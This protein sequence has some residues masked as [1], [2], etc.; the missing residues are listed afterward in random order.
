MDLRQLETLVA[1]AEHGSF[2]AAAR[3]MYTVQSNVSAHISRLERELGVT[4]VDRQRG[5]LTDEGVTLVERARRILH[6]IQ[7][8][9]TELAARGEVRGDVRLGMIGTTARWA[10][11]LLLPALR[12]AYPGIHPLIHEGNTTNLVPRL[13]SGHLDGITVHLPLDEPDL[14]VEP[15]FA[16][17]LLLLAP[18][19]HRLAGRA[20]VGLE[21]LAVEP[22]ILPP[23][24]TAYRRV[25]DRAA[26]AVGISLRPIAEVDGVRLMASLAYEGFGATIVPATAIPRWLTGEFV[27]IPV[28][29]LPRRVVA[30]AQRKRPA[31]SSATRAA[32]AV[33]REVIATAGSDQTGVHVGQGAFPLS[34]AAG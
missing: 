1:V 32:A 6:D 33:L 16:E 3:A 2:S 25:L 34:R 24:H 11:P 8:V 4:L 12:H 15:L 13:L 14:A 22:L 9:A 23:S 17:D 31:P 28:P 7:D 27:R 10:V 29:G 21:E 19:G 20:E 26:T 5:G 30:W 18:S